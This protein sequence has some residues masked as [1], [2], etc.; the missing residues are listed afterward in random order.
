MKKTL[1]WIVLVWTILAIPY[2]LTAPLELDEG[3]FALIYTGLI[4]GMMISDIREHDS[5]KKNS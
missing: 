2:T 1:A 5:Q 3:F 4:I